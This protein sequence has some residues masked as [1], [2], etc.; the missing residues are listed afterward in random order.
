MIDWIAEVPHDNAREKHSR[1][2]KTDAT[3]LQ[4]AQCHPEHTNK[5]ERANRVRDWLGLVK[6]EQPIHSLGQLQRFMDSICSATA[7]QL[8]QQ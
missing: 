5:G 4:A 7:A 2:A 6:L 8:L 3:K 1:G